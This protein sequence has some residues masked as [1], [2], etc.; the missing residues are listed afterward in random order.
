MCFFFY[1]RRGRCCTKLSLFLADLY[2]YL[3]H[4]ILTVYI[5]ILLISLAYL[6]FL[7]SFYLIYFTFILSGLSFFC[8]TQSYLFILFILPYLFTSISFF[9]FSWIDS[10]SKNKTKSRIPLFMVC[11]GSFPTRITFQEYYSSAIIASL[12]FRVS[13]CGQGSAAFSLSRS[14]FVPVVRCRQREGV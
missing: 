1:P 12:L 6:F 10:P 14:S 11:L 4:F 5:Y 8:L 3:P 7:I 9:F 13:F 2:F